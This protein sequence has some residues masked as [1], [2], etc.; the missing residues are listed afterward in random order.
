MTMTRG[1]MPATDKRL[2][3]RSMAA[4]DLIFFRLRLDWI[5][6]VLEDSDGE[7]FE[8]SIGFPLLLISSQVH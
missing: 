4:P 1:F 5:Y 7:G 8:P 2:G 6:P 3:G